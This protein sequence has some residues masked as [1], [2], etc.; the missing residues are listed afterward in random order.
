[1][2]N[3]SQV[4]PGASISCSL[5]FLSGD[6]RKC[7]KADYQRVVSWDW[8]GNIQKNWGGFQKSFS[9]RM[10]ETLSLTTSAILNLLGL[11]NPSANLIETTDTLLWKM[12]SCTYN[13]RRFTKLQ[14][15][16]PW[17]FG[18]RAPTLD[19]ILPRKLWYPL[20]GLVLGWAPPTLSTTVLCPGT[21]PLSNGRFLC[22]VLESRHNIGPQ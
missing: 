20:T 7:E 22:Q 15:A 17:D 13:F 8:V 3:S 21:N 14:E 19:G 18:F 9:A 1:M 4:E 5:H 10:P 11:M 2:R 6:E 12:H 16:Q